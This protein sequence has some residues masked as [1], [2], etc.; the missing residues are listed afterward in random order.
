M[1]VAAAVAVDAELNVK[2]R[3]RHAKSTNDAAPRLRG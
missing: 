2:C 1:A 3:K